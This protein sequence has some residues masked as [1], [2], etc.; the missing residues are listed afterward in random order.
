MRVFVLTNLSA[1]IPFHKNTLPFFLVIAFVQNAGLFHGSAPQLSHVFLQYERKF[2]KFHALLCSPRGMVGVFCIL[3]GHV[4]NV[5]F[6]CKLAK[7]T[8]MFSH[9]PLTQERE[10]S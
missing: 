5:E 2:Q 3:C 6:S 10:I 7:L 8:K 9:Y 4:E 1:I